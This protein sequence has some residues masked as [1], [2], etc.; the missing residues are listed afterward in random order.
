MKLK[1]YSDSK[2]K[3]LNHLCPI[4]I[5]FWD[6]LNIQNDMNGKS[7]EKYEIEGKKI[8]EMSELKESDLAIYPA[9]V[10]TDYKKFLEF[11][12]LVY[13]KPVV[14]FFNDDSDMDL[15]CLDNTYIFRTSFYKSNQ[16]KNEFA[17]PA[18]FND[19]GIRNIKKWDPIPIVSFCGQSDNPSIREKI[20]EILEKSKIIKT[21][22]IRKN[23]FK[24][25]QNINEN[26]IFKAKK[27]FIEN[28]SKGNY[29]PCIRGA[30]NFSYRIYETMAAG[31]IPILINTDCVLPYD[32]IIDYKNLFL[33]VD[34]KNI[35][36]IEEILISYHNEIHDN[37]ENK[38]KKNR[39]IWEEF[40]SPEGFFKNLYRHF[41]GII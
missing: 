25:K 9:H 38:Q 31:R 39:S 3:Q 17:M 33:V 34:V 18:F 23:F 13:P 37:F 30:G 14:A 6:K 1:I 36:N 41:Q 21:D 32:F 4:L 16:K 5:P 19:F 12:N 20:L 10:T 24:F 22:F 11:Q 35:D 2:F 8:F 28:I 7:F 27:E 40:L 15:K 26:Y 29:V